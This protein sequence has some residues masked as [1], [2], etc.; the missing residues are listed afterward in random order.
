MTP[1]PGTIT[2]DAVSAIVRDAGAIALRFR[3]SG[4]LEIR[5]KGVQ[6]R[7]T[8]ADTTVESYLRRHL[9]ALCPDVG[10][11]GEEGGLTEAS[12]DWLWVVDPIDGTDNFVR[13][14]DH[15]SVSVGLVHQG[16]PVMGVIS[17]PW[18][19]TQ[20]TALAGQGAFRNGTPLRVSGVTD[21]QRAAIAIGISRRICFQTGYLDV[22]KALYDQGIEHRRFGSAAYSLCQVAEGIVEGYVE[23]HLN[24]WDA[25]AGVLI[26]AE[27]GAHVHPITLSDPAGGPVFVVTPGLRHCL[28]IP[29][30]SL[31]VAQPAP[32][33]P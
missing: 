15:W 29:S 12:G 20:F 18:Q 17:L 19:E 4:T 27:A 26:A 21:P 24:P 13:G 10:F 8:E 23:L 1:L 32:M 25:A 14:I 9:S 28:S 30:H 11:L 16:Q 31:P 22:L 6:D 33:R 5:D 7:V 2:L 3:N